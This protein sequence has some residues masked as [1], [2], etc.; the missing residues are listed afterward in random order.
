MGYDMTRTLIVL[1]YNEW[2]DLAGL[3]VDGWVFGLFSI[4]V[5]HLKGISGG[6]SE[7][8][9]PC[10][11]LF[12]S[13]LYFDSSGFPGCKARGIAILLLV[14]CDTLEIIAFLFFSDM[15]LE[16]SIYKYL[17]GSHVV[18]HFIQMFQG[19]MISCHQNLYQGFCAAAIRSCSSCSC[20]FFPS[21]AFLACS[22]LFSD[23][24]S[25]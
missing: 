11:T 9:Q 5:T 7:F 25:M 3:G 2:Y 21:A 10:L 22:L 17:L 4:L 18:H 24:T 15:N 19:S 6:K 12:F 16:I 20:S 1:L 23:T 8:T 13:F 14:Q